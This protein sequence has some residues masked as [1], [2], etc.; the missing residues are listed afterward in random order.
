[1]NAAAVILAHNHPSG[2]PVPSGADI[3]MTG[4]IKAALSA[5]NIALHDHVII[6]G[7]DHASF[8]NLGLL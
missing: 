8:R 6:G 5:L 1:M 2:D 3:E 4:Q 7:Q